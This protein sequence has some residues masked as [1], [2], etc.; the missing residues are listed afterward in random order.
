MN[1]P[2]KRM[3]AHRLNA[4]GDFYVEGGMCTACGAPEAQAPS[5]MAHD[6]RNHYY[7]KR[8]PVTPSETNEAVMAIQVC[9][10]GAVRY[11]GHDVRIMG[12]LA[13]EDCDNA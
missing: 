8:Q 11:R 13:R 3:A 12:Q 4:R 2:I 9:C 6:E 5:L 7:F 1:E 10:C